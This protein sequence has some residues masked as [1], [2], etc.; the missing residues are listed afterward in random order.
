MLL[1]D[2]CT[3]QTLGKKVHE[4]GK[5]GLF[6]TWMLQESDLIQAAARAYGE[7]IISKEVF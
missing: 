6:D 2:F 4:A 1:T 3:L 5:S 7:R